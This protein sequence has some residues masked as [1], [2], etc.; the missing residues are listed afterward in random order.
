MGIR[1]C[2]VGNTTYTND[3]SLLLQLDKEDQHP[4]K[5]IEGLQAALDSL[6]EKPSDGIPD[7][8]LKER[9]IKNLDFTKYQSDVEER[10]IKDNL[11]I[12]DLEEKAIKNLENILINALDIDKL[13]ASNLSIKDLLDK[14]NIK[15]EEL[16]H[17]LNIE[18]V[19]FICTKDNDKLSIK[20]TNANFKALEPTVMILSN[21]K[22]NV[23]K[24]C[25]DYS[26]FYNKSD[27]ICIQFAHEGEYLINY[28]TGELTDSEFN[29]LLE[30]I[31]KIERLISIGSLSPKINPSYNIEIEYD[32]DKR[33]IKEIYTGDVNKEIKYYYDSKGNIIRKNVIQDNKIYS[34]FYKYDEKEN[35]IEISDEGTDIPIDG[36]RGKKYKCELVYDKDMLI[37]ETYTGEI[38]KKIFY[39]YNGKGDIY[40]KKVTKDDKIYICKYFYDNNRNLIKIDDDGCEE[41]SIVFH[42]AN[43]NCSGGGECVTNVEVISEQEIDLIFEMCK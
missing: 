20:S 23:C 8:D 33:P 6:Y 26:V 13:K 5:A 41:A 17:G 37:S 31:K 42:N 43:N 16:P 25:T 2:R 15:D 12:I 11:K 39:E 28:I 22:Y 29:I 35:L 21:G 34:A 32:E 9:Y 40:L 3:H 4:I 27:T 38:E 18:Q 24:K 1:L 36:T 7:E 10:L 14:L 19:K 30:Y